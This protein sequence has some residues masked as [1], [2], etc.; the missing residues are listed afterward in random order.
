MFV[1]VTYS[2]AGMRGVQARGL[3][4]AEYLPRQEVLFL[5]SGDS[6]W[7][8]DAG[9][10]VNEVPFDR[11]TNLSSIVFP[12]DTKKVI[13][14]DIPTNRPYQALLFL[15]AKQKGIPVAVIENIYRRDQHL[16]PVYRSVI[17]YSDL[18]MWNGL[19]GLWNKR[20]PRVHLIPPLIRKPTM[21]RQE[22]REQFCSRYGVPE[23]HSLILA[24][25][26]KDD[27][28]ETIDRLLGALSEGCDNLTAVVIA[29]S[30]KTV[31]RGNVIYMPV[32][33]EEAIRNLLL[34]GDL[35]ICKKGYLQIL[36][37]FS[38]GTPVVCIG[39]HEGFYDSW[40]E[41]ELLDAMCYYPSFSDEL[42]NKVMSLCCDT[43]MRK[44]WLEKI[45][46]LHDGSLDGAETAARLIREASFHPSDARKKVLVSLNRNVEVDAA[47][48][49]IRKE[50]FLLPIFIS[51]PYLSLDSLWLSTADSRK[52]NMCTDFESITPSA[53]VLQ[54][55]ASTV[56]HAGP[57]DMHG[58]SLLFPWVDFQLAQIASHFKEADEIIIIGS[59][60]A[61]YLSQLLEPYRN[62][63]RIIDIDR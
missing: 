41:P 14:T 22:A 58:W 52:H 6:E 36:E 21:S 30:D 4:I 5:N 19:S 11:I 50:P 17:E 57:H 23:N 25:G 40:L 2:F 44:T 20:L 60:T 35:L 7:L 27:V 26:Y 34:A 61:D 33:Q 18:F 48:D 47:R 8:R 59:L 54:Y 37:S 55:G 49:I 15:A 29:A 53:D 10:L 63:T 13:F 46:A 51:V 45:E 43:E 24:S 16:E 28:R 1:F 9:Y 38:L 56:Y 62:K 31:R 32:L 42:V 12:R 39:R 3:R